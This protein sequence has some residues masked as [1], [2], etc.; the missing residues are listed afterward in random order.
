VNAETV[1]TEWAVHILGMD[2]VLP[3]LSR[4]DAL[5]RAHR[6]NASMVELETN[7]GYPHSTPDYRPV[8]WAEPYQ[9]SAYKG[10][11]TEQVEAAWKEWES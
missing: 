1:N 8:V 11:T 7:P 3:A 10:W 9:S 2:D 6:V 4:T 5:Q